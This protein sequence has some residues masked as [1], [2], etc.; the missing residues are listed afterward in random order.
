MITKD[1]RR[2]LF[3]RLVQTQAQIPDSHVLQSSATLG[4]ARI[5]S[6]LELAERT[7]DRGMRRALKRRRIDYIDDGDVN[8]VP[9]DEMSV[10][11]SRYNGAVGGSGGPSANG[12]GSEAPLP[13]TEQG[14]APPLAPSTRDSPTIGSA[15]RRNPDGSTIA[16]AIKKRR[17]KSIALRWSRHSVSEVEVPMSEAS[18]DDDS[19]EDE[20]CEDA[21][22]GTGGNNSTDGH[23]DGVADDEDE[24]STNEDLDESEDRQPPLIVP[25][26]RALCFKDWAARQILL[27]RGH[28]PPVSAPTSALQSPASTSTP[29]SISTKTQPQKPAPPLTTDGLKRG[30]LG[31][32]MQLPNTSLASVLF[33]TSASAMTTGSTSKSQILSTP[34]VIPVL[35]RPADLAEARAELPVVT[36]EQEIVEALR[37][38]PVVVIC[39]PTGSGKTTQVP[40]MLYE[41]GFGVRDG[42]NPGMIG[43]TQPR[44]VAAVALAARVA[45][46]MGLAQGGSI[47]STGAVP[48]IPPGESGHKAQPCIS[49][50]IRYDSTVECGTVIKF[51]T[52]GVLLRELS[53]DFLL[54]VY[55]AIV[56]DEAHERTL[57]T[58]ILVGVLSRVVRLREQLWR[59]GREGVRPLRLVI[60]SATLRVS[61]FTAN[62]TLFSSP[63]PVLSVEGRQHPVTVHFSR[64]TETD[65][66]SATVRKTARIHARLPPGGVLVFLTG[67]A[68][69]IGVCRALEARYGTRAL[70][71]RKKARERAAA[72]RSMATLDVE[73]EDVD[74]GHDE[75][76]DGLA[77]DVDD[78]GVDDL[79]DSDMEGELYTELGLDKEETDAP[80]HIVP[81]YALLPADQQMKV[82]E[83][84]PEGSRLVIVATNVAETSLTIPGIRYVVDSGRAKERH[85]DLVTGVQS[86]SVQWIS[87][88]SAAQRAGR[89][90]RTGPGHCYRL[91]SSA[92]FEHTFPAHAPPEILRAPLAGVVLQMKALHLDA[93]VRFPFPTPPNR[94][95]LAVAERS[96]VWMGAVGKGGEDGD[97]GGPITDLG[98]TMSLFPLA[99]RFARMLVSGNQHGCLPYIVALVAALS[100]GD[101][102][103][104]EEAL[105]G[106]EDGEDSDEELPRIDS[107]AV[108]AKEV[109]RRRR[110]AFFESQNMH[111]S[112]GKYTSDQFRVLSVVGAYEYAGG[113]HK[114]CED[115][116]VRPKAMEEIHK[117]RSQISHIVQVNFSGTDTGFSPK[118]RPPSDLQIKVLRQLLAAGFIDQVAVRK[119]RAESGMSGAKSSTST[120]GAK[121]ST[122]KD[123][124]YRALGITEDV[125]IH[126]T[127]LLASR[128]PP[129]YVVFQEVVRTSRTWLKGVT[130]VNPA[131]LA[132]LGKGTLCTFSKPV[133]NNMG[134]MMVTPRFGPAGWELPPVKLEIIS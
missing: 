77:L 104:R 36:Q 29:A 54:S 64:H 31:A 9:N 4:T 21:V 86:F 130:I 12:H 131:W 109:R 100:V 25:V 75:R 65:Y 32:D 129:E 76:H 26:K 22:S 61:D 102:F 69:I 67:Q 80:M 114:F 23:E 121:H 38:Y 111:A 89:A 124:A 95:A 70:Q 133:K 8:D 39:G 47:A 92:V 6:H 116:F 53:R 123:V 24:G 62:T 5:Q 7:E 112:L 44:R 2:V 110:K 57:N 96:L 20:S 122:C 106:N 107:A 63:P 16:P 127:S 35:H 11:E 14:Q 28:K 90:G 46:E 13:T 59:E 88:A 17:K 30:P 113:G 79:E 43:V 91:Y 72:M 97:L 125:Y 87:K 42:E 19:S 105:G 45:H 18:E 118:L 134:Q 117:L 60:M 58:D 74:L 128:S 84:P 41:A 103:L 52:D 83:P 10:D 15:L 93:V 99:P 94:P 49:Y 132:A 48:S 66:V 120:S 56:L 119:D 85:T 98:Y 101:P 82:F 34:G 3:E 40:Q 126:P 37:L 51:M 78:T 68:E 108:K 50:Q 55:S 27:A 71:A 73:A 81:L 33:S 1:N 115:H